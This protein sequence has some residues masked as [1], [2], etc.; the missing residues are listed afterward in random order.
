[1]LHINIVGVVT[2]LDNST[3]R[4]VT[5]IIGSFLQFI[6]LSHYIVPLLQ[7]QHHNTRRKTKIEQN[8]INS[9]HVLQFHV[10]HFH[11][12]QFG[13]SFSCPPF[14][15][16]P[17]NAPLAGYIFNA[18]PLNFQHTL[19][20][21]NDSMKTNGFV[22]LIIHWTVKGQHHENVLLDLK[23]DSAFTYTGSSFLNFMQNLKSF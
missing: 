2:C 19:L 8:A 23:D 12:L 7:R 4:L 22:H 20:Q 13:P 16:P 11:A 6:P 10:L 5:C 18:A 17:L 15:A 21:L 1:M 14:S 3:R 9:C